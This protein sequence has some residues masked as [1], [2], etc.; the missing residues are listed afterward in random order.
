ML[1]A[2]GDRPVVVVTRRTRRRRLGH[3]PAGRHRHPR[4]QP[5]PRRACSPSSDTNSEAR[6]HRA[7]P[8]P[9][10]ARRALAVPIAGLIGG[11]ATRR[12]TPT[13]RRRE[14]AEETS[15]AAAAVGPASL[16]TQLQNERNFTSVDLIG[17]TAAVELP[18]SSVAEARAATDAAVDDLRAFVAE[19]GPAAEAAFAAGLDAVD[20][21]LADVRRRYDDFDGERNLD[22]NAIAERGLRFVPVDVI[23]PSSTTRPASPSRSTTP[24]SA[25]ASSSST[26]RPGSTSCRSTTIRDAVFA[27][28]SGDDLDAGRVAT[29]GALAADERHGADDRPA[30]RRP[31]RGHRRRRRPQ[32][33]ERATTGVAARRVRRRR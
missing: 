27:T 26:S 31:L 29:A 2:A 10:E 3:R 7:H 18:V 4:P 15:L 14:A 8:D 24:T 19:R 32:R 23:A 17:L 9:G 6:N 16:V 25:P 5:F 22:N 20:S 33:R 12:P 13:G 28:L 11:A 30:G 1:A 21:E